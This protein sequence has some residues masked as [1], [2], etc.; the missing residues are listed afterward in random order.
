MAVFKTLA[1]A[2]VGGLIG[3]GLLWL[4]QGNSL[5]LVPGNMSYAELS[6]IILSAVSVLVTILGVVVAILAI[7]G[8][9][10]FKNIAENSAKSHVAAEMED[11]SL[12]KHLE[13]SVTEFMQREFDS[14]KL[15]SMLEARVDQILI[16]GPSQRAHESAAREEDVD[17]EL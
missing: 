6:A 14:G 9:S 12:R 15:R 13:S 2:A 7:W 5:R 8:Y 17:D 3:A 11:G 16:S 10:H 1:A 4:F